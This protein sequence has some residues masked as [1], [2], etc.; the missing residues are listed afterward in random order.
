MGYADY[1]KQMLKPLGVYNLSSGY[2]E[3]EIDA[4]GTMLD[5]V[6]SEMEN[7]LENAAFYAVSEE[8]L[9][10]LEELFPILVFGDSDARRL[11]AVKEFSRV[12][13]GWSS[14]SSL[15]KQLDACGLSVEISEGDEKFT[16]DLNFDNVRGELTAQETE[17]VQ[18]IMPAHVMLNYICGGLTWD[19][20]EE[21]FP[22]WEDFDSCGLTA[23]E[24]MKLQ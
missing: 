20:A 8:A 5:G 17:V 24:M 16:V 9:K 13:D 4:I 15:Q 23:S 6:D 14:V 1:L 19:R 2:G 18:S 11:E 21:L 10:K 7:A 12:N 22:T 3:A